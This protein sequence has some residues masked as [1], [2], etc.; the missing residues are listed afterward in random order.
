MSGD[1]GDI[2][3]SVKL[4]AS[5]VARVGFDR[6]ESKYLVGPRPLVPERNGTEEVRTAAQT[7]YRI[8]TR[9]VSQRSF[10]DAELRPERG[11]ASPTKIQSLCMD[12][13]WRDLTQA[14]SQKLLAIAS[15]LLE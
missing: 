2:S 6:F 11:P 1:I 10:R 9:F 7:F 14:I 4:L 8:M 13:G 12:G 15:A 5:G 3:E